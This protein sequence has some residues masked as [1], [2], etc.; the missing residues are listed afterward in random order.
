MEVF[1]DQITYTHMYSFMHIVHVC[2]IQ[3]ICVCCIYKGQCKQCVLF[4]PLCAAQDQGL[5]Y[6]CV[7]LALPSGL[8]IGVQ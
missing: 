2:A 1:Q 6:Y 8:H 3:R 7:S 4:T 5:I